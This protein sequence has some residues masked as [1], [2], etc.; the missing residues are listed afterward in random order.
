MNSAADYLTKFPFQSHPEGG[1]YLE[2][3]RSEET[4]ET[5]N[6]KRS[7]STGIYFLLQ[8]NEKSNLH[9]IKSDEMWHHYDGGTLEIIEIHPSG[10]LTI[11]L[12]GKNLEQGEVPQYVVKAGVIF[13][14]RPALKASF[15]FVGCTV[16]PGFDFQD[17]KLFSTEEL[18]HD[19]PQHRNIIEELTP[20]N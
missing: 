17:F 1:H 2:T 6:G 20:N 11:T 19:Y 14:S 9:V 15:V 10:E 18:I 13:G 7:C 8:E 3:Y 12:L 4:V 5:A 16:A